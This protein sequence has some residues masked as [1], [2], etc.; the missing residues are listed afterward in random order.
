[1]TWACLDPEILTQVL[2]ACSTRVAHL[3]KLVNRHWYRAS[4]NHLWRTVTA[5]VFRCLSPMKAVLDDCHKVL[6]S[7]ISFETIQREKLMCGI[8]IPDV[9]YSN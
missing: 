8:G 3:C 7:L 4:M 1:M 6:V 9:A 5:E 2:S